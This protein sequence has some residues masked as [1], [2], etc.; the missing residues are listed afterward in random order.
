MFAG[1]FEQALDALRTEPRVV[2]YEFMK[3]MDAHPNTVG[4]WLLGSSKP[5]TGETKVRA[6]CYFKLKGWSVSEF[7]HIEPL[8]QNMSMLLGL[9]IITL[10]EMLD[11]LGLA[12]S[13]GNGILGFLYG[14]KELTKQAR[15]L[16]QLLVVEKT[17]VLD[18]AKANA[19]SSL[20]ITEPNSVSI[21]PAPT[22]S[23]GER[24]AFLLTQA[25]PFALELN[26][27]KFTD[28]DRANMRRIVGHDQFVALSVA[29]NQMRSSRTRRDLT[30]KT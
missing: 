17:A 15:K 29:L 5:P 24:L 1:T 25:Y 27:E 21:N 18:S 20:T 13:Y 26:T 7:E 4:G 11:E 6:L 14:E 22:G 3:F 19:V 9:R 23:V 10:A 12:A 16:A 8:A 2:I 28:E 30:G